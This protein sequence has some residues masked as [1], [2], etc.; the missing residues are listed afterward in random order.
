M[1]NK[2]TIIKAEEIDA[3]PPGSRIKFNGKEWIRM[4]DWPERHIKG[5]LFHA[6]SG[7]WYGWKSLLLS[8]DEVELLSKGV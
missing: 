3:L 5:Q 7:Y 4:D 2:M 8:Q 6:E 1:E